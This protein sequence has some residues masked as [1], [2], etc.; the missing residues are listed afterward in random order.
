MA[1]FMD[2]YELLAEFDAGL[3]V[4]AEATNPEIDIFACEA[5][6]IEHE[7]VPLCERMPELNVTVEHVSTAAGVDFVTAHPQAVATI[8][9]HH[10]EIRPDSQGRCLQRGLRVGSSGRRVRACWSVETLSE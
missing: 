4:D 7:R 3:L 9:P 5:A 2:V 1:A 6:F 8:T 10:G